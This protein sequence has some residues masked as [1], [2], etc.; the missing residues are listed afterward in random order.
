MGESDHCYFFGCSSD[1]KWQVQN[2]GH[3]SKAQDTGLL[4]ISEKAVSP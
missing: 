2:T 1:F 4:I 3:K